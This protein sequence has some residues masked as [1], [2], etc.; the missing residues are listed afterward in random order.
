MYQQIYITKKEKKKI[1]QQTCLEIKKGII[2]IYRKDG[3][4]IVVIL[5]EKEIDELNQRLYG[6]IK[7]GCDVVGVEMNSGSEHKGMN[8]VK[9]SIKVR[10]VI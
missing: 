3:I 4:K 6:V 7:M 1:Y 5:W 9:V 2:N 10:F 8:G